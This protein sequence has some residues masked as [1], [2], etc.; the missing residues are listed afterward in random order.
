LRL[1]HRD[2]RRLKIEQDREELDCLGRLDALVVAEVQLLEEGL[3]DQ[4]PR[5]PVGQ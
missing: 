2:C 1:T 4:S 3:V 5:C